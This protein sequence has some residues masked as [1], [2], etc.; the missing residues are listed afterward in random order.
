MVLYTD[1]KGCPPLSKERKRRDREG[2]DIKAIGKDG[3]FIPIYPIPATPASE[4]IKAGLD[5]RMPTDPVKPAYKTNATGLRWIILEIVDHVWPW[6]AKSW[7]S[8]RG[9]QIAGVA[10]AIAASLAW[11]LTAIGQLSSAAIIAWWFGWSVY[12]VLIRLSGKRYVKDG[13]WWRDNYRYASVMDMI[14]YVSF[15]N[16]LIGAALFLSLKT[17]GLLIV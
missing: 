3:Y 2:L 16:L 1:V 13:P 6:S 15:K 5:P 12:E 14:S 8:Q 11:I 10:L 17:L 7:S 4:A 9:L